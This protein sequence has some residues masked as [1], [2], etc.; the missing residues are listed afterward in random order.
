MAQGGSRTKPVL[1]W[2]CTVCTQEHVPAQT[3]SHKQPVDA[4]RAHQS[5]HGGFIHRGEQV[6]SRLFVN[7][8]GGSQ[9]GSQTNMI[10]SNVW[11]KLKGGRV[12]V[13]EQSALPQIHF[14]AK[15]NVNVP[16]NQRWGFL[17]V[18]LWSH[19]GS[20]AGSRAAIT[21]PPTEG[22]RESHSQAVALWRLET[23]RRSS[24]F[25]FAAQIVGNR[26]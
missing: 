11:H 17:S 6:T 4:S 21:W 24:S 3:Q 1:S 23:K 13:P 8:K 10:T 25:L 14:W 7:T 19:I 12:N 20:L 2:R 5:N 18:M 26:W 15:L 16:L 9:T 22:E